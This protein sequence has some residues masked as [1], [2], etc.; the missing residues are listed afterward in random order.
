[1]T[2]SS[3]GASCKL[4]SVVPAATPQGVFFNKNWPRYLNYG[5]LG[6]IVGHELTHAFHDDMLREG[7]EDEVLLWSEET[8][9]KFKL[10]TKCINSSSVTYDEDLP[11]FL[12][13]DLAILAYRRWAR[14]NYEEGRLLGLP[15]SQE[16]LF[17]IS[18]A[19]SHCGLPG[20]TSHA[21][22]Q[23]R[24]EGPMMNSWDFSQAFSCPIWS[25]MNP[26][27]KCQVF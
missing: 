25:R 14:D 3:I 12:G 11:D 19:M 13:A 18:R 10:G 16:Q 26:S 2:L 1:M 7:L 9:E 22:S 6:M 15:Y 8:F 5:A 27:E 24:V 23:L 21:S 20:V 4:V 17:W